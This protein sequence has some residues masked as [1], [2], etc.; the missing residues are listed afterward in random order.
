MLCIIEATNSRNPRFFLN[1][2][3]QIPFYL[4]LL[5]NYEEVM[6]ILQYLY[7]SVLHFTMGLD[8][9]Q[10]GAHQLVPFSHKVAQMNEIIRDSNFTQAYNR[11]SYQIFY[12]NIGKYRN[13]NISL[14][15]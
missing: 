15:T 3:I 9:N 8:K 2:Q 7:F 12:L 1:F 4:P 5:L 11:T 14:A 10:D 13:H 6:I